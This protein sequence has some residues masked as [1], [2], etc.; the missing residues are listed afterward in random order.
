MSRSNWLS[1]YHIRMTGV[2]S[3]DMF[4]EN[5]RH[6]LGRILDSHS[7]RRE[8]S[9]KV[10]SACLAGC[11]CRYNQKAATGKHVE[12]LVESGDAIPICPEQMGGLPTPRNPA[13]I[14]GGDGFDVLD[15]RAKV[16][17]SQGNDV[18][19]E[20]IRGA[21]QAHR[22][23]QM[24]KAQQAIL[25][26]K[27]P[28]CGSSQIYDGSFSGMTRSGVGVTAALFIRNGISVSSQE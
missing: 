10:V 19:D 20:F 1:M 23:A 18:T 14:V 6:D 5:N 24:V 21:E 2:I 7:S 26:P 22:I 8:E 12:A 3:T 13:E 4:F 17:D 28:S 15:G 27:S 11:K 16:I 25:K 9:M